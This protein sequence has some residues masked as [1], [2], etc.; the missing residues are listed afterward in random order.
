MEVE[1]MSEDGKIKVQKRSMII[2]GGF[3]GKAR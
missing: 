1:V 3:L 2:G